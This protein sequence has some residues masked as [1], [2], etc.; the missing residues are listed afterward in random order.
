MTWIE[1]FQ[2]KKVPKVGTA[3]KIFRIQKNNHGCHFVLFYHL[4]DNST[5]EPENFVNFGQGC[6]NLKF[7]FSEQNNL[8]LN[9][10]WKR[11]YL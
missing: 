4:M 9:L 2:K 6:V 11:K 1:L 3:S 8:K 7:V 10:F 5:V